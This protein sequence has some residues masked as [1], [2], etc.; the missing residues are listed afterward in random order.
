[1]SFGGLCYSSKSFFSLTSPVRGMRFLGLLTSFEPV[2]LEC[3]AIACCSDVGS[4][5]K[6]VQ[7]LICRSWSF[8]ASKHTESRLVPVAS[9]HFLEW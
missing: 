9:L 2:L 1:M 6:V 8:L 5:G 3:S 4:A 7:I